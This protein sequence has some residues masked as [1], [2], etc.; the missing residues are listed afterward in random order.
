VSNA[1]HSL[2][3]VSSNKDGILIENSIYQSDVL[4]VERYDGTMSEEPSVSLFLSPTD[5]YNVEH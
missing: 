5:H 4:F 3:S 2:R 1:D